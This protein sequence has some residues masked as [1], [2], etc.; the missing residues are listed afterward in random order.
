MLGY[1]IQIFLGFTEMPPSRTEGPGVF[2]LHAA[3]SFGTM[4]GA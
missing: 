1:A 4:A 2:T 3:Q